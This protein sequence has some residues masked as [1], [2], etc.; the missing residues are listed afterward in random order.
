[1]RIA[2]TGPTGAIGSALIDAA[3]GA[4]NEVV[5]IVRPD[6]DRINNISSKKVTIVKCD[7]SNLPSI[8][9][10][11]SCD[12]FIHLAWMNT[13]GDARD[14]VYTQVNNIRYAL[15]A[16]SLAHSWGAKVFV[17]AG[18]QAEYGTTTQPLN[19]KVP[20]N[21]TSGYGIAKYSAGKLCRLYCQ[22]KGIRFNWTRILS[23][24]GI[25]DPDRTLIMYLI[26]TFLSGNAP[27]LT[28]CEQM[29]DYIYSKD[30]AAAIL[31]ICEK[32]VDGKT[33]CI[34]SGNC[35][36]LKQYVEII[37]DCI[38]PNLEVKYGVKPYYPHQAMYLNADITDLTSDT[39]FQPKYSFKQGIMEVLDSKK[40]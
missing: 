5:A 37:R 21:P 2:I 9:G 32:G 7:L 39:G 23:V 4:G 36:P 18:S 10:V 24:Y 29:W 8:V 6:S 15:D 13:F 33:Y 40:Y 1:M 17:G 14:D 12:I 20:V 26:K 16:V 38:N 11:D 22:Q 30:A 19:D 27:E 35:M 34:G 25:N 31:A 3:I 28:K